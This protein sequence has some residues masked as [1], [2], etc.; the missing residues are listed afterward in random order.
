MNVVNGYDYIFKNGF[1]GFLIFSYSKNIVY[2]PEILEYIVGGDIMIFKGKKL[3]L[4]N[5]RYVLKDYSIDIQ[6]IVRS[7]ILD[8]ID[9]SSYI[10][11]C[12]NNPSRLEQIR[13]G[14]KEG[15]NGIFFKIKD[16]TVLYEIRKSSD[17]IR[18]TVAEKLES[19]TVS[20]DFIKILIRWVS[21]GYN[22]NGIDISIIPR[23]LYDTFTLGFQRG[24]DMSVFNDGRNY[25]PEYI[26]TCLI[27]MSNGK[28]ISPFVGTKLWNLDCLK[29]ISAFSRV[30][31]EDIWDSLI[32][33]IDSSI[34]YDKLIAL[35]SC[36]KNGIDISKLKGNG[37]SINSINMVLKAYSDG[38]DY[39]SL[40]DVGPDEERV[41]VRANELL[42]NKS[43]RVSG[44]FRKG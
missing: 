42:L 1:I 31:D 8:D 16:G 43:K 25:K 5:F 40:I 21:K 36:V 26:Q 39:G 27:I 17:S 32:N 22:L 20:D 12:K 24:F 13:L 28:S 35:V 18:N 38:I 19:G 44:R 15:I 37:W 10:S 3:L 33:H 14:M 6:D 7:A 41:S 23:N 2:P 11:P 34:K 29:V 30:S 4:D 9:I